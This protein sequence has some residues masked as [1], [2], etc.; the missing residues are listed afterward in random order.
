MYRP[1]AASFRQKIAE[2][3]S[4]GEE[5]K[6][7][8]RATPDE[9]TSRHEG[10]WNVL[11]DK[12]KY[13]SNKSS[14]YKKDGR[15]FSIEYGSGI[16]KGIYSTD[17]LGVGGGTVQSQTFAEATEARGSIFKAAKFDGLLGLGY[18][19]LAEDNVVPVFDNMIKQKLLPKSVFSIYLNRQPN[20][21]PGGEIYF[22]DINKARYTG[23]I[24]YTPVTKKSYWQFRMEGDSLH[25]I[26]L[27]R[28]NPGMAGSIVFD[29]LI[30]SDACRNVKKDKTFCIGGCDAVVDTGSSFIEGPKDE[31]ERL[32]SYLRATETPTGEW[33]VK[34]ANIPKMPKIIFFIGGKQFTMTAEEYV[35][36]L[37]TPKKLKCF[38]G[39]AVSDTP[40]KKF[41]V[42][43][44]V[45]IGRFYTIF[46]RA[47]DRLGFANAV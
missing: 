32:N 47:S 36:Q 11:E 31:I 1:K 30:H 4:E 23:D 20:A 40:T 45:F 39:F 41:W 3:R 7:A 35:I 16:V 2:K 37:Q 34:C 43:G 19:A 27:E 22:G 33:R 26:G 13:D 42:L 38:S 12:K 25:L 5:D 8:P 17:V 29:L 15:K 21:V 9:V 14:T 28:L 6:G 24:T 46:D 18:P 10:G 44:Q